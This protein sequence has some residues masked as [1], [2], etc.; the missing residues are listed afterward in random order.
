[1]LFAAVFSDNIASLS[2]SKRGNFRSYMITKWQKIFLCMHEKAWYLSICISQFCYRLIWS[3][4]PTFLPLETSIRWFQRIAPA[5]QLKPH[6]RYYN[7]YL[8][9]PMV[10]KSAAYLLRLVRSIMVNCRCSS[11]KD[12][13]VT[14]VSLIRCSCCLTNSYTGRLALIRRTHA[15]VNRLQTCVSWSYWK[16]CCA[17][18]D[19]SHRLTVAE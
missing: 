9:R 3:W 5:T 6:S 14:S 11:K 7:H 8:T 18:L 19:H 16:H 17:W 13:I 1:M 12:I 15:N 4:R 10:I 2:H